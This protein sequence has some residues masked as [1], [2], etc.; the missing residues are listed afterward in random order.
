M[1]IV[2]LGGTGYIGRPLVRKLLQVGHTVVVTS[3][4]VASAVPTPPAARTPIAA[5]WDGRDPVALAVACMGADAVVNL[6]GENIGAGR[7]TAARRAAILQ[8][9][10]I[11]GQAVSRAFE[12]MAARP[13]VLI[14]GSAVGW[15]GL[16]PDF[17]A[18]PDCDE[19]SPAGSGFLAEV[20]RQWEAST[21]S[22]EQYNVRRVIIRTAPVLGPG[23]GVLARLLP[24]FRLGLGGPVGS[25]RQPFPWIHLDDEVGAIRHAL[26]RADVHGPCNLCAPEQVD[27]RAFARALGRAL[28]RPAFLTAPA[29]IMR[30]AL[31][32]MAEELL[33][34]GQRCTP[35][36]LSTTEY[37]F[38]YPSLAAALVASL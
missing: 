14:Q 32:D 27:A 33:L 34:N 20:C 29:F 15:Y 31:G 16:W 35:R 4:R 6:L 37:T 1:R 36:M 21:A 25:G 11:A 23:G 8:S 13:G 7:W 3:R 9:R 17:S 19:A 30:A 38:A 24:L 10:L 5:Q 18:A 22:V 12:G 26:E 28:H 2:V